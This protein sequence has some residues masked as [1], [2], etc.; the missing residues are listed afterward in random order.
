MRLYA[1][2]TNPEPSET[3]PVMFRHA[4]LA[5]ETALVK[6]L[7]IVEVLFSIRVVR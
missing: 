6:T 7:E 4:A 5:A 2:L 1:G 3:A